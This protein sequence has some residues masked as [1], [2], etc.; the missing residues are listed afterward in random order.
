MS[1][2]FVSVAY[3]SL[4]NADTKV[5][6]ESAATETVNYSKARLLEFKKLVDDGNYSWRVGGLVR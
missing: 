4:N 6:M 2:D 3:G 5:M 1:K